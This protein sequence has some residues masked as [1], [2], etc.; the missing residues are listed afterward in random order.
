MRAMWLGELVAI[1]SEEYAA[2][3]PAEIDRRRFFRR[4]LSAYRNTGDFGG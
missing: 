1:R 4:R 2:V 3:H